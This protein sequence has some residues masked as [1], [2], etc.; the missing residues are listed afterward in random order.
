VLLYGNPKSKTT[1]KEGS[2]E[3]NQYV[4]VESN[5]T[6]KFNNTITSTVVDENNLINTS[7]PSSKRVTDPTGNTTYDK[8][9][10]CTIPATKSHRYLITMWVEGTDKDCKFSDTGADSFA[11]SGLSINLGFYALTTTP[12]PVQKPGAGA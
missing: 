3:V 8:G 1:E 4:S 7:N 5:D 9:Y 11:V 12:T 10:L 2:N 6:V